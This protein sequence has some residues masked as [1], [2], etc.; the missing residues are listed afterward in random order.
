MG[1]VAH[2]RDEGGVDE[3]GSGPDRHGATA[4]TANPVVV[5]G[6]S[7]SAVPCTAMRATISGL[8]STRSDHAPVK[9][10]AAHHT[11]G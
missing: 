6:T 10:G 11:P 5:V 2:R 4:Q 8:R 3:G 7:A 1:Y 9:S